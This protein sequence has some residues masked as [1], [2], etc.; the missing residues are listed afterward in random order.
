MSDSKVTPKITLSFYVKFTTSKEAVDLL[1]IDGFFEGWDSR[2]SEEAFRKLLHNSSHVCL[3]TSGDVLVGF[4]TAH[5][6]G[7]LSAYIPLL[8]VRPEWRG[9]GIGT[10]LMQRLLAE[11][12]GF[13]MIDITCDD[14]VMPFYERF[15]FARSNA[16]VQR[17]YSN[18]H[19]V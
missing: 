6:D 10:Q 5:D 14:V 7:V 9:R 12:D 18:L 8:E 4:A 15:N 11:L 17:R 19:K 13:Y 16:M 1:K 3:A 2:P